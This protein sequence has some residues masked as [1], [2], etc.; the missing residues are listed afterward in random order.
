LEESGRCD[1]TPDT[2]TTFDTFWQQQ[3]ANYGNGNGNAYGNYN[4]NNNN[5]G[6]YYQAQND[7]TCT[8]IDS[9]PHASGAWGSLKSTSASRGG[10]GRS[11]VIGLL[12]ALALIGA[13]VGLR[14]RHLIARRE[15]EQHL[16]GMD[17]REMHGVG[18]GGKPGMTQPTIT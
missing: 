2:T 13:V 9:L 10:I 14:L 1:R 15:L 4:N 11:H 7:N 18:V 5:N 16:N 12:V 8:F 6:N 17:Y 3:Q